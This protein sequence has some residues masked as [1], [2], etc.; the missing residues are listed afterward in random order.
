MKTQPDLGIE[1]PYALDEDQ[2]AAAVDLLKAQRE[3]V[4][5]YWSD[6][7]KEIQAFKTGDSRHRHHL[8]G[9]RRTSPRPRRPRS[10]RSCPR[11]ARPAGRTPGW[12]RSKTE[13]PNCA[14]AWL[15]HII[16]PEA[17]AAV[18]EW[19]GEAPAN[20]KACD[21]TRQGLLRDLPRRR[22][23][24]RRADPLLDHADRA[25][26]RRAHGREV[27][28]VP[29]LDPGLDRDQGLTHDV[30]A[31]AGGGAAP[32]GGA[33]APPPPAAAGAAPRAADAVAGRGVPRR[34]RR[35]CSSRRCG[36][37]TAS[38][39]TSSGSGPSTT[40]AT[41]SAIDVYRTITVRTLL[42]AVGGDGDR[43]GASPS[44]SRSTWPRSPRPGSSALLV[45]AVLTPLW[46]SYLVKA[47][48]WRGMFAS[49]RPD[50]LAADAVRARLAGL[51][52]VRDGRDAGLPVAAVHDPADV[53]RP[54]A[55][56]ELPA[57]GVGRPR[58]RRRA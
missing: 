5:E 12:S 32:P 29:G 40:S 2:L 41:C 45:I 23:G 42:I 38:P 50:R 48:A 35:R 8:A 56:A 7:L 18:A 39:A 54:R 19:F 10:R 31:A 47:Y 20:A 24:L 33:A 28:D 22:R 37:P 49:E 16:S 4:G 3:H 44:R 27:H 43:R 46:A 15:N 6:Y 21:L 30:T 58:R 53:R 11:R 17:N 55:A 57:R 13:H 51:R 26:P 14:Y 36:P 52:A 34:A 25:V 1:D 9:H